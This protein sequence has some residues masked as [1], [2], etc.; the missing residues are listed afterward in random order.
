MTERQYLRAN[1]SLY[2]ILMTLY[3]V[4]LLMGIGIMFSSINLAGFM[5][6]IGS[7]G[8]MIA[9]TVIYMKK[10]NTKYCATE[11]GRAHV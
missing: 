6:I 11:I 10:K 9:D 7:I 3:G 1:S 2:P 4:L 8:C 5:Q